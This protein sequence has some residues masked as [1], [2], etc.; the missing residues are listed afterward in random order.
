MNLSFRPL[1]KAEIEEFFTW[2]YPPPYDIYNLGETPSAVDFAYYLEPRYRFHA[3]IEHGAVADG[4]VDHY[5]ALI[6]FCSFGED[7]Q[8]AGG[9][10]RGGALDIGL[11]LRPNHT[12]Q[13]KGIDYV[14][15][16][17]AFALVTYEPNAL[18]VTIAAFN[19]R[20]QKVWRRAGFVEVSR[21]ESTWNGQP[22]IVYRRDG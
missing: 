20:A 19:Q 9:E 7:G 17:I 4:T 1:T 12:G 6:G 18:R 13:G 11:A 10:Y 22:F 5:G 15:Q 8:V 14:R 16:V 2:R 3:M 21:F